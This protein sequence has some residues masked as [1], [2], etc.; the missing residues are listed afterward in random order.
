MDKFTGNL[1]IV[2]EGVSEEQIQKQI[3]K[4]TSGW[5]L[6][7]IEPNDV[8]F[9]FIVP[10]FGFSW[11]GEEDSLRKLMLEKVAIKG[12]RKH[13]IWLFK[14]NGEDRFAYCT[15]TRE[16]HDFNTKK[17]HVMEPKIA[18]NVTNKINELMTL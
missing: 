12:N 14:Y 15:W 7:P 2:V 16:L 3:A 4:A 8:D 10:F 5:R 11:N 17:Y 6:F 18:T 1:Q 9:H 13:A